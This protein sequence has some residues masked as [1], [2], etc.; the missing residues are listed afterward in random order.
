[1]A[2]TLNTEIDFSAALGEAPRRRPGRPKKVT[3]AEPKRGRGQPKGPGNPQKPNK[4]LLDKRDGLEDINSIDDINQSEEGR[5]ATSI[6]NQMTLKELKFISIYMTGEYTQEQAMILAGYNNYNPT[7]ARYLACR[8]LAKYESK[9]GDHRKLFRE[10]GAGES[11]V[12]KTL[13]SLINTSK[14][15]K[16]RL[17][18]ATQLAKCLGLHREIIEG[19]QPVRLIIEGPPE[20]EE[21][22]RTQQPT[23]TPEPP[24][25]K[26]I[27]IVK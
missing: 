18:A 10:M 15:E 4:T 14:S 24:P 9:A 13:L 2:E 8:I 16:I 23:S 1:M 3:Q 5:S 26:P 27:S 11:L 21:P 20:K 25:A 7:Y 19:Q 6:K 17:D 22:K 12:V